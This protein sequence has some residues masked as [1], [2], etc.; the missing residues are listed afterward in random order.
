M[1]PIGFSI[2]RSPFSSACDFQA[3]QRYPEMQNLLVIFEGY[4]NFKKRSFAF[5]LFWR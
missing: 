3:A 1:I 5:V 2:I 4:R